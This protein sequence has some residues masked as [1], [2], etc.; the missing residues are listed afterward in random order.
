MTLESRDKP[1]IRIGLLGAGGINSHVV[2][3]LLGGAVPGVQLVAVAGS[4]AGSASAKRLADRVGAE[5]VAPD[6]LHSC[7]CDWVVEA[8]GGLAVR[9]HLPNLWQSGVNTVVMSIGALLDEK[10]HAAYEAAV[11]QG[12]RI[13][14]PS[15]GIAGLDGVRSLA[16][17]G[18]LSSARIT[19]TK[20]PASLRGAP[21]LESNNIDLSDDSSMTVFEGSAREAVIG[22][23]ANVNVAIALSLAGLGPDKTQVRV[24]SDPAA[25]MTQQFIEVEGEAAS[26]QV[27]LITK[28]SPANPRT[29]YLAGASAVAALKEIAIG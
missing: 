14:L 25:A 1:H 24:I 26:M 16:A 3:C 7:G 10:V 8:A 4:A 19:T 27:R 13:V 20:S 5:V 28:P 6:E 17:G 21:Y 22:F 12:V 9:T 18:G 23:P 29:S 11:A 2:D 15:G